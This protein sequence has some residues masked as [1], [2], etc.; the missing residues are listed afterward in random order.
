[1][2]VIGGLALLGGALTTDQEAAAGGGVLMAVGLLVMA[3][4]AIWNLVLH[5]LRGKP[6]RNRY[7]D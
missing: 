2:T 5:C 6:E 7:D 3:G 1:V 4:F